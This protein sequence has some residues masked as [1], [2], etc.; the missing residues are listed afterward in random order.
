MTKE[1]TG[2]ILYHGEEPLAERDEITAGMGLITAGL[3]DKIYSK[4]AE[5]GYPEHPRVV[6]AADEFTEKM[7]ILGNGLRPKPKR[8]KLASFSGRLKDS[9]ELGVNAIDTFVQDPDRLVT[10]VERIGIDIQGNMIVNGLLTEKAKR[11][12]SQDDPTAPLE[13]VK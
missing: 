3:I 5:I 11:R 6:K 1:L 12:L 7:L 2:N 10:M 8:T 13:G 9:Y 4:T